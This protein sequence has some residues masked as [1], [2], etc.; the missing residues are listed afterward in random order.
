MGL[1]KHQ[2]ADQLIAELEKLGYFTY[3]DPQHLQQLKTELARRR[4]SR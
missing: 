1:S 4:Y 3:T 2:T